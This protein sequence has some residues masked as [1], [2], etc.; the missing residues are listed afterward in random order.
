MTKFS[1]SNDTETLSIE[2]GVWPDDDMPEFYLEIQ[3]RENC[4]E[5]MKL[6]RGAFY[7]TLSDA[8]A[9]IAR[10]TQWIEYAEEELKKGH[11]DTMP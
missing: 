8:K 5:H 3:E 10:L 1:L 6:G 2:D 7:G 11:K 4:S 9:I